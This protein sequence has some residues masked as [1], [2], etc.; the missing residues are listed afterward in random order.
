MVRYILGMLLCFKKIALILLFFSLHI[1]DLFAQFDLQ[2]EIVS[3]EQV[4]NVA[5]SLS[6]FSQFPIFHSDSLT[7]KS[8]ISSYIEHSNEKVVYFLA[9]LLMSI[10]LTM[11]VLYAKELVKTSFQSILNLNYTIRGLGSKENRN[12]LNF[13]IFLLCFIFLFSYF[14]S[15]GLHQFYTFDISF[16]EILKIIFFFF[17]LDFLTSF[18][19]LL[20]TKNYKVLEYVHAGSYYIIICLLMLVWLSVFLVAY[21]NPFFG[22]YIFWFCLLTVLLF[23]VLREV[24]A[25]Q[26]LQSERV[27]IFSFQFFT[28]LC[29]FKILPLAIFVTILF[30]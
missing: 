15:L 23:L 1:N 13:S 11:L 2:E 29:T 12:V 21:S 17:L 3:N 26:I 20:F 6:K 9:L 7:H 25:I 4:I 10:A 8:Q 28:Y 22:F 30:R 18:L 24:R 5:D 14:L 27:D 19:Y 16:L